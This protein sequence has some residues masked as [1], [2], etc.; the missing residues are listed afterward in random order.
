MAVVARTR[1]EDDEAQVELEKGR[2]KPDSA[3]GRRGGDGQEKA[4][5]GM[6]RRRSEEDEQEGERWERGEA[7]AEEEHNVVGDHGGKR[8][9]KLLLHELERKGTRNLA[10]S[11]A[12]QETL[13]TVPAA[14][15]PPVVFLFQSNQFLPSDSRDVWMERLND[16]QCAVIDDV[17]EIVDGSGNGIEIGGDG[18]FLVDDRQSLYG[19]M[20]CYRADDVHF[21]EPVKLI[22]AKMLWHLIALL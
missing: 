2:D 3:E 5:K 17:R 4:G 18:V 13:E 22:E 10:R 19:R 20:A 12:D 8:L 11:E 21:L 16:M 9:R 7:A 1:R 6:G 14:V 15:R